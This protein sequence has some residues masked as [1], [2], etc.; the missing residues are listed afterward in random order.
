VPY[1]PIGN[2]RNRKVDR[3]IETNKSKFILL[4]LFFSCTVV[5]VTPLSSSRKTI[6]TLST[7]L[8]A[9]I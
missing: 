6:E 9:V 8:G 4:T 7:E 2:N 5:Y 1:A 3:Q